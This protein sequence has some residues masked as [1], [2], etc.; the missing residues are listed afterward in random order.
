MVVCLHTSVGGEICLSL[1]SIGMIKPH[2]QKQ[3][4]IKGVM[5]TTIPPI[6]TPPPLSQSITEGCQGRS[7]SRSQETSTEAK[8]VEEHRF[9]ACSPGFA[10]LALLHNLGRPVL[11]VERCPEWEGPAHSNQRS[12]KVSHRLAH[13]PGLWRHFLN[14]GYLFLDNF[15]LCQ[16]DKR[17]N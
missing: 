9:W 3:L 4:G 13:G 16:T 8:T 17:M 12:R 10:Q 1:L 7:L 6:P 11:G 15:S 5:S 2:D 14:W